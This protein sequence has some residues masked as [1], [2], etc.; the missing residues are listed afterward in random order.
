MKSFILGLG[1]LSLFSF[2]S[3]DSGQLQLAPKKVIIQNV[4]TVN[5]KPLQRAQG[6][7]ASIVCLMMEIHIAGN[8]INLFW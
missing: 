5:A 3:I 4:I 6:S 2:T 1:I 7:N 8:T